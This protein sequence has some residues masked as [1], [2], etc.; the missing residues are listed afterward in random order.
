MT[1]KPFLITKDASSADELQKL[2]YTLISFDGR[3]YTF[4]A[5]SALSFDQKKL[6]NVHETDRLTF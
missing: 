5:S 1:N 4:M 2:G 6:P 3:I